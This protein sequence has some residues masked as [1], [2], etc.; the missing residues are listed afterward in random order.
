MYLLGRASAEQVKKAEEMRGSGFLS[1]FTGASHKEVFD[2]TGIYQGKD[3]VWRTIFDDRKSK[4]NLKGQKTL[5]STVAEWADVLPDEFVKERYVKLGDLL[6]HPELYKAFPDLKDLRVG[7]YEKGTW[8]GAGAMYHPERTL[9]DGTHQ[10][11]RLDMSITSA[12][13]IGSFQSVLLHEIQ[14]ALQKRGDFFKKS[15][16]GVFKLRKTHK[17]EEAQ[18][19]E[20]AFLNNSDLPPDV[21]DQLGL[22]PKRK[23]G[24]QFADPELQRGR[25]AMAVRL[26]K[27]K[28]K[29][30]VL[31]TMDFRP[32][33]KPIIVELNEQWIAIPTVVDGKELSDEEAL[34]RVFDTQEHLGVFDNRKGAVQYAKDKYDLKMR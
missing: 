21:I 22:D 26:E 12:K 18:S 34:Q 33:Q 29:M 31:P 6:D 11:E 5:S 4:V 32:E 2:E 30:P 16:R 28:Y 23:V 3:D 9:E 7:I 24:P 19:V 17:E 20:K 25:G 14:H 8:G 27:N 13:K 15:P 1:L 10:M